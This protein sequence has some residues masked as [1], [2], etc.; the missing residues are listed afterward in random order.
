MGDMSVYI[1]EKKVAE[2]S[3]EIKTLITLIKNSTSLA[4]LKIVPSLCSFEKT[5]LETISLYSDFV[6]KITEFDAKFQERL[7]DRLK[8]PDFANK[9]YTF[10]NELDKANLT[11][12]QLAAFSF[13]IAGYGNLVLENE[14]RT[15]ISRKEN[16]ENL[17]KIEYDRIEFLE[18]QIKVND[19]EQ[20]LFYTY[21]KNNPDYIVLYDKYTNEK[22]ELI[23]ITY[24]NDTS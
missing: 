16:G 4:N 11:E 14:L 19:L 6:Q 1:D 2:A 5:I 24:K 21:D 17:S 20:Q 3:F 8:E 10:F 23:K 13:E 15:L 9:Y 18:Q 7:S 12:E 22:Q